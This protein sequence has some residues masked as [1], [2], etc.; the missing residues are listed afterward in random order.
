MSLLHFLSYRLFSWLLAYLKSHLCQRQI[1]CTQLSLFIQSWSPESNTTHLTACERRNFSIQNSVMFLQWNLLSYCF[2]GC[3]EIITKAPARWGN[4]KLLVHC[5]WG[6][7]SLTPPAVVRDFPKILL[8]KIWLTKINGAKL[9]KWVLLDMVLITPHTSVI[10]KTKTNP[11]ETCQAVL[12][13]TAN[14]LLTALLPQQ[15]YKAHM[16]INSF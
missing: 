3:W 7:I 15:L 2:S 14:S 9:L 8:D 6:A 11:T 4:T 5:H 12:Q 13:Q 10:K 16:K 1:L